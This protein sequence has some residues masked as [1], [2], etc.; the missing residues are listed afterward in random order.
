M[1]VILDGKEETVYTHNEDIMKALSDKTNGQ[2][3]LFVVT[4]DTTASS[5]T[6][7]EILSI[8]LINNKTDG[9]IDSIPIRFT[10]TM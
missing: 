2:N 9:T 6:Y 1:K 7:G 4:F 10:L 5:D 3:K 8:D